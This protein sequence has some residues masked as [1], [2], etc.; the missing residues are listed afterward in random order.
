MDTKITITLNHDEAILLYEFLKRKLIFFDEEELD[1]TEQIAYQIKE[2][3]E[4]V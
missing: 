4:F 3:L 1:E 2:Q